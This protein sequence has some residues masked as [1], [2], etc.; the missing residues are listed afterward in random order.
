MAIEQGL[1]VVME[2]SEQALEAHPTYV[3]K[4]AELR[5]NGRHLGPV[6]GRIVAEVLLGLLVGDP[7]SYL[8]Q[9]P[10][11]RPFLLGDNTNDFTL[12]DLFALAGVPTFPPPSSPSS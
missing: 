4:E 12:G 1:R 9:D 7:K 10:D 2:A 8:S 3:L 6:G 11:W 5:H